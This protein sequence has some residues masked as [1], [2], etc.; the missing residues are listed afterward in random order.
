M[1]Q[2]ADDGFT[3]ALKTTVGTSGTHPGTEAC[4]VTVLACKT[5]STRLRKV[6]L[7]KGPT[8]CTMF[9]DKSVRGNEK[10]LPGKTPAS[11]TLA[12]RC[13]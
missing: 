5:P 2:G 1:L 10:A 8:A 7:G 11:I 3:S 13:A 4:R 9:E 6:V 12:A